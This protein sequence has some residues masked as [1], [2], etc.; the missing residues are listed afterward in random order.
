MKREYFKYD[1]NLRITFDSSIKYKLFNTK[2][3]NW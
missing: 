1:N 2:F 3:G